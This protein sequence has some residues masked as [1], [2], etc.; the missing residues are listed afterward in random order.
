MQTRYP[1]VQGSHAYEAEGHTHTYLNLPPPP[2]P[3]SPPIPDII[4]WYAAVRICAHTHMRTR[5]SQSGVATSLQLAVAGDSRL[6]GAP[7]PPP[8]AK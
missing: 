7:P 2:L 5:A 3:S 1:C 6:E 4:R 8:L